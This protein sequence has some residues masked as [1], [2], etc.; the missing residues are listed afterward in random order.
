MRD[1]QLEPAGIHLWMIITKNSLSGST[2]EQDR[3][4][5]RMNE[6]FVGIFVVGAHATYSSNFE[7]RMSPLVC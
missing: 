4:Y 1:P 5:K 6:R 7:V 3:W 2:V